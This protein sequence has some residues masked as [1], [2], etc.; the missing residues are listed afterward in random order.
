M[1]YAYF[2]CSHYSIITAFGA[3]LGV[4]NLWDLEEAKRKLITIFSSNGLYN[5]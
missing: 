3:W 2:V 4:I 1:H 5:T